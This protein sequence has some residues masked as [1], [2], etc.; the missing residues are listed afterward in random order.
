MSGSGSALYG[1][2]ETAEEAEE[3]ADDLGETPG[4]FVRAASS[5]GPPGDSSG[6]A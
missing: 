6:S 3:I 4:L 1:I 5:E 2:V